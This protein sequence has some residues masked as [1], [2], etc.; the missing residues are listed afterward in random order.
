MFEL[1]K[2]NRILEKPGDEMKAKIT[3]S[4]RQVFTMSKNNGKDKYSITT[5]PNGTKVETKTTKQ[6]G[7]K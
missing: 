7:D 5:Y 2:V 4:N 6:K 3:N 1:N